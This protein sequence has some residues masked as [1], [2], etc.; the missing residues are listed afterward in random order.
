[1]YLLTYYI[2]TFLYMCAPPPT[3]VWALIKNK[4]SALFLG[5]WALIKGRVLG[6][7]QTVHGAIHDEEELQLVRVRSM[8]AD[9]VLVVGNAA[10]L[11]QRI[12]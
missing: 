10:P 7:R 6:W 2:Y 12:S 5:I 11:C 4:A 9:D 1:M 3:S 8:Q